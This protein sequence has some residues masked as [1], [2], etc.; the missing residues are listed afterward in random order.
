MQ[1]RKLPAHSSQVT[2]EGLLQV[3]RAGL[4]LRRKDLEASAMDL[5]IYAHYAAARIK[6][7]NY[8]RH[9]AIVNR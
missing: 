7:D 6:K 5:L 4:L 3:L 2:A 8:D 1:T 9:G